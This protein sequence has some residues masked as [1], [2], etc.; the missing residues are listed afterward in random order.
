LPQRREPHNGHRRHGPTGRARWLSPRLPVFWSRF[1]D[2]D[3]RLH[4]TSLAVDFRTSDIDLGIAWGF[5]DWDSVASH[6]LLAISATPVMSPDL[7]AKHGPFES[8]E[9]LLAMRLLHQR[10]HQSWVDWFQAS[11]HTAPQIRHGTVIEDSNVLLQSAIA[12]QGVALGHLPFVQDDLTAGR[13]V[14]PFELAVSSQRAYYL[15]YP[16]GALRDPGLKA[17]HDCLLEEA[18]S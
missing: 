18:A 5:G 13:L 2:I 6:H 17:V 3:L 10:D 14:R 7:M 4:H 8:P 11:G 15:I 1:P 9:D 16:R 12:G